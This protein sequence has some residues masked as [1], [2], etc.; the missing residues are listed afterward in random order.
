MNFSMNKKLRVSLVAVSLLALSP[1]AAKLAVSFSS[2]SINNEIP[3]LQ[4]AAKMKINTLK[5]TDESIK[6]TSRINYK[7]YTQ[8]R[9]IRGTTVDWS[10]GKFLFW[11]ESREDVFLTEIKN[12]ARGIR[13]LLNLLAMSRSGKK[14]QDELDRYAKFVKRNADYSSYEV[15]ILLSNP[16]AAIDAFN[17]HSNYEGVNMREFVYNSKGKMSIFDEIQTTKTHLDRYEEF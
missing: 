10:N 2:T 14:T 7:L 16:L 9:G 5:A 11:G 15:A 17:K 6:L 12:N 4:F 8:L 3:A 13:S 1:F